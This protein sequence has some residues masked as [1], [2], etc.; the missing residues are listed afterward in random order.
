MLRRND[1]WLATPY[2][3]GSQYNAMMTGRSTACYDAFRLASM[4]DP[5]R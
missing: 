1:V 2:P 4:N 5:L 3:I